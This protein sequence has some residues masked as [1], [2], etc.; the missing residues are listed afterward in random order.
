M[1]ESRPKGAWLQEEVTTNPAALGPSPVPAQFDGAEFGIIPHKGLKSVLSK[2]GKDFWTA[3]EAGFAPVLLGPVGTFKSFG[4]AITSHRIRLAGL[5][6]GWCTVPID[7]TEMERKRYDSRTDERIRDW[8]RVPFLVMD[9]FGMVKVGSWQYD[10]MVEIAM[11][12]FNT[13]RPTLWTGNVL[14]NKPS[15]EALRQ[16]M[17]DMLG[18]QL[19]RRILERSEGYRIYIGSVHNGGT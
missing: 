11:E 18:A 4:A 19:T 14:V 10:V 1:Q 13:R 17:T 9:D 6:T 7:L 12:R 2:Y 5:R 8:K 16:T 3:A 15:A